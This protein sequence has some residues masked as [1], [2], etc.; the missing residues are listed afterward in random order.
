MKTASIVGALA[1]ALALSVAASAPGKTAA[2]PG[3]NGR[4]VF[5]RGTCSLFVMNGDGSAQRQITDQCDTSAAWSPNGRRIAFQRGRENDFSADVYTVNPDGTGLARVTFTNGF[6]GDPTWSPDGTRIAFES[7]RT[8]QHRHLDSGL[9]RRVGV[10]ADERAGIR[11]RSRLV[12]RRLADRLHEQPQRRLLR[13]E[14]RRLRGDAP[15]HVAR[16]RPEPVLVA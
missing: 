2:F 11:R 13:H 8:K 6:D 3:K 16:A 4:I 15:D 1:T 10:S 12:A 14:H 7:R 5:Q 9:R